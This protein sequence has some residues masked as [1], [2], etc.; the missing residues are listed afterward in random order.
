MHIKTL[1]SAKYIVVA[2][3]ALTAIIGFFAVADTTKAYG[4]G[5]GIEIVTPSP[6]HFHGGLQNVLSV[7]IFINA[8][9]HNAPVGTYEKNAVPLQYRITMA[10]CQNRL[11][12]VRVVGRYDINGGTHST[13]EGVNA[14][15][16]VIHSKVPV[17]RK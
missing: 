1:S 2:M 16:Q 13:F 9:I 11:L 7:V 14:N 10:V 4:N 12:G 8:P 6:L 3:I 15:W 5:N 17:I